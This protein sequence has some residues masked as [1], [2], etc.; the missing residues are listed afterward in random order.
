M[1]A[2]CCQ[3]IVSCSSGIFSESQGI[4]PTGGGIAAES[5]GTFPTG[6]CSFT[7]GRSIGTTGYGADFRCRAVSIINNFISAAP[8]RGVLT[9]GLVLVAKSCRPD[10]S[11]LGQIAEGRRILSRS[12]GID[13]K[14]RSIGLSGLGLLTKSRSPFFRCL[15]SLPE[16]RGIAAA[17]SG[18]FP[19]GYRIIPA[20]HI[21][22][23]RC[24]S[25]CLLAAE[26]QGITAS[27]CTIL[28]D[29]RSP[30]TVCHSTI[31]N[32]NSIIF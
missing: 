8:S 21:V 16:G 15:G 28:A 13:A 3:R 14:S 9:R 11:C 26:G 29:N 32:S 10:C 7:K 5:R 25:V 6:H 23:W 27:S 1:T 18:P 24:C 30:C 20:G 31:P 22:S 12:D 2:Q 4:F 19:K 17:G